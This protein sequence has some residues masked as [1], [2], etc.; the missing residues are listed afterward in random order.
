MRHEYSAVPDDVW[1]IRRSEV[2]QFFL[3]RE[4]IFLTST[5]RD[6]WESSARRNIAR[7]LGTLR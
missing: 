5:G 3:D 6:R 1:L 7:E 2:L 4:R